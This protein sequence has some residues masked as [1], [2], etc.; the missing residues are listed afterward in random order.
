MIV[1]ETSVREEV[2]F[3]NDIVE[4]R[5]LESAAGDYVIRFF[6][7]CNAALVINDEHICLRKGITTAF[8]ASN[9]RKKAEFV[10]DRRFDIS[11]V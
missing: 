1:N 10:K 4:I 9:G 6:P 2:L 7:Y 8:P 3:R 5:E 11:V